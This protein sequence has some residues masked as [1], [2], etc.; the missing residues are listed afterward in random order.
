MQINFSYDK[1]RAGVYGLTDRV[2]EQDLKD[3]SEV[4]LLV[5][6]LIATLS[7]TAGIT[8]P[9]G[10]VSEGPSQGKAVFHKKITFDIFI[11]SNTIALALSLS[12]VISHYCTGRLIKEDSIIHQLKVATYCSLGA[13]FAMMVAF[14]TGSYTV[15]A[16]SH[17]LAIAVCV[18]CCGF[19]VIAFPAMWRVFKEQRQI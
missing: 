3:R 1:R 19:F 12:A 16:V 14:M 4:D 8:V 13:I 10:Y 6:A 5:A 17:W 15:L 2:D 7:F 18:V 11:V 9:G